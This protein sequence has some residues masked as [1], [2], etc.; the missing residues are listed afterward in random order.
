MLLLPFVLCCVIILFGASL[1][2]FCFV[3]D[4]TFLVLLLFCVLLACVVLCCIILFRVKLC[5][6]AL[7]CLMLL[8]ITSSIVEIGLQFCCVALFC[9]YNHTHQRDFG[10]KILLTVC[11]QFYPDSVLSL[12]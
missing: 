9:L 8:D 2:C 4:I 12:S 11:L 7:S 10:F 5:C 6:F 3:S 1:C